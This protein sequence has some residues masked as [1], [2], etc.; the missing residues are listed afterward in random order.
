MS[1]G[2]SLSFGALKGAG[3]DV[4]GKGGAVLDSNVTT[5]DGAANASRG[6][7]QDPAASVQG[8]LGQ[9]PAGLATGAMNSLGSAFG[10]GGI[11]TNLVVGFGTVA[12]LATFAK[13]VM[14]AG[15]TRGK[16]ARG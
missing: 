10:P 1:S 4:I 8:S 2:M 11:G 6:L 15:V 14:D 13:M 5:V 16:V 3:G 7:A 12:M 9:G